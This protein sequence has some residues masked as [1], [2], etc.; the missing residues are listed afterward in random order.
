[1]MNDNWESIDSKKINNLCIV[2]CYRSEGEPLLKIDFDLVVIFSSPESRAIEYV[3]I[4]KESKS[5]IALF[6]DFETSG[7]SLLRNTNDKINRDFLYKISNKF[8][9]IKMKIEDVYEN[10]ESI[11]RLIFSRVTS[12]NNILIDATGPPSVY[13]MALISLFR[14]FYPIPKLHILNF[15]GDYSSDQEKELSFTEGFVSDIWVPN[16]IG[17]PDFSK[18]W[19]YILGLGF[20]AFRAF[21]I[22]K[23]NEPDKIICIVA[24]PGYSSDY[25]DKAIN[26]NIQ[27]LQY[28]GV[29]DEI[30]R[31]DVGNPLEVLNEISR[32]RNSFKKK[33]NIC[34]VPIG[35]K[36]FAIGMALAGLNFPDDSILY[37]IPKLF[38][39]KE[40]K[41]N[42]FVWYYKVT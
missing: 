31:I 41:R 34:Y 37:E 25:G 7:S 32:I 13:S 9:Y 39:L 22:C 1:M 10:I 28:Y 27:L 3:K 40:V 16:Y 6:I 20:E 33:Y 24:D 26:N 21:N 36:P 18:P 8:E 12:L 38:I 15:S 19:L 35:P 17:H 42:R 14:K 23:K 29:E 4:L 11:T 5:D 30:I 2:E